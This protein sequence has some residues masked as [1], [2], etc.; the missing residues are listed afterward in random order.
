MQ[1][2]QQL[3]K[4]LPESWL[5]E[6]LLREDIVAVCKENLDN[7]TTLVFMRGI[8]YLKD[9]EGLSD[10]LLEYVPVAEMTEDEF[11]YA[12]QMVITKCMLHD[13]EE[14]GLA[15]EVEDGKWKFNL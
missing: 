8:D 9:N 14:K 4:Q 2:P 10:V 6:T 3:Q 11:G 1:L 12:V 13:L 7:M 5:D 15:E